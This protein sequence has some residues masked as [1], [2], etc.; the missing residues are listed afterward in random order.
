[1]PAIGR[2]LILKAELM[3]ELR[4]GLDPPLHRIE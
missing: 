1:V 3:R 2:K 4:D